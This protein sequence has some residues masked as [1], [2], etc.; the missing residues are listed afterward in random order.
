MTADLATLVS[1]SSNSDFTTSFT[2]ITGGIQAS[3]KSTTA[4][5]IA[6][7][8]TLLL[9]API[10]IPVVPTTVPATYASTYEQA[11]TIY[12]S[13]TIPWLNRTNQVDIRY[14]STTYPWALY[15]MTFYTSAVNLVAGVQGSWN[16]YFA[17]NASISYTILIEVVNAPSGTGS[18]GGG[19]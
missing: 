11:T 18:S 3:A 2:N 19:I 9:T 17:V 12:Y 10:P 16:I 14:Y 15:S 13:L 5:T 8:V 1:T 6:F 4:R 7:K